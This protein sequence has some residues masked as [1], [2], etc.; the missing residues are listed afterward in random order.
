MTGQVA[1]DLHQPLPPNHV[2]ILRLDGFGRVEAPSTSLYGDVLVGRLQTISLEE[3]KSNCEEYFALSYCW[4]RG[5]YVKELNTEDCYI[6]C[7]GRLIP[8]QPNL[9]SAL[10]HLA[11][12]EGGPTAIWADALC[13]DQSNVEEKTKQVSI[14]GDIYKSVGCVIAWFGPEGETV[15]ELFA[16]LSFYA[17]QGPPTVHSE[18]E[19]D[20][21]NEG[22]SLESFIFREKE[23]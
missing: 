17:G 3:I 15:E 9:H 14:M 12:Q 8:L 16:A 2:R 18:R 23:N 4:Q 22:E 7:G 20:A 11:K 1:V 19:I 6:W 21:S 13:I 10:W 5:E